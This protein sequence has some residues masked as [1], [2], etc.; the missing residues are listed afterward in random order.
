M[1]SKVSI[2]FFI[3][4]F[5]YCAIETTWS[6]GMK[7]DKRIGIVFVEMIIKPE[8][9]NIMLLNFKIMSQ[10]NGSAMIFKA[11]FSVTFYRM[12]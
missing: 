4:L 3:I 2:V 7:L 12:K 9:S 11:Y 8:R 5:S 1:E 10:N 6:R